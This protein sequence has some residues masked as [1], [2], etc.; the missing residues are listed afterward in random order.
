M[1]TIIAALVLMTLLAACSEQDT[2]IPVSTKAQ[3][4]LTTSRTLRDDSKPMQ[5]P[6]PLTAEQMGFG[7]RS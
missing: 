3:S 1:K 7:K 2:T 5:A 6:A 4:T